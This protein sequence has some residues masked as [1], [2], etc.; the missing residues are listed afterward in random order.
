[1]PLDSMEGMGDAMEGARGAPASAPPRLIRGTTAFLVSQLEALLPALNA[2]IAGDVVS[3]QEPPA[4]PPVFAV[5]IGSLPSAKGARLCVAFQDYPRRRVGKNQ[6]VV[7]VRFRIQ[8]FVPRAAD[9]L[10]SNFEMAR[11]IAAEYVNNLLDDDEVMLTPEIDAGAWGTIRA[12]ESEAG[13]MVDIWPH[14]F[15]DRQTTAHGWEV[16]YWAAYPL[17]TRP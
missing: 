11:Q 14:L 6:K 2:D 12:I 1:M 17:Q 16:P 7:T 10:S 13:D 8:C 15:E 5:V 3:A 9:N 4:P